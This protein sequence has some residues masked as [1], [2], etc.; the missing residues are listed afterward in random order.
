VVA[1]QLTQEAPAAIAIGGVA[2]CAL[3]FDLGQLKTDAAQRF[4][5][6]QQYG[7]DYRP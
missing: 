3:A 4:S 6:L 1:L 2:T 5:M 7:S